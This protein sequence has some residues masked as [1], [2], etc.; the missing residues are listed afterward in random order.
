MNIWHAAAELSCEKIQVEFFS[1]IAL[2]RNLGLYFGVLL[3]TPKGLVAEF[4]LYS[5]IQ[6]Q[7]AKLRQKTAP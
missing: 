6:T 4:L 2:A 7:K 3:F 1:G 5:S